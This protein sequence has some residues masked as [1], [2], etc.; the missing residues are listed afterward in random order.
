MTASEFS[1]RIG[2]AAIFGAASLC[3][4]CS[5]MD[6]IMSPSLNA[7]PST[8]AA[9]QE[10]RVTDADKVVRLPLA[11]QD[12][13]CPPVEVQDGGASLRV[14]GPGRNL[15]STIDSSCTTA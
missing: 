6:N 12:L 11:P 5:S 7:K 10:S 13:D 9:A 2:L 8:V 3:A 1:K 14:G 15:K 4:A